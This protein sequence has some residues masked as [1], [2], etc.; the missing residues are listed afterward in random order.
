MY[1]RKCGTNSQNH[2]K[3]QKIRTVNYK[4]V[5]LQTSTKYQ[6]ILVTIYRHSPTYTISDIHNSYIYIYIYIKSMRKRKWK[7]FL[8]CAELFLAGIKVQWDKDGR[9]IM[10]SDITDREVVTLQPMTFHCAGDGLKLY[11]HTQSTICILSS[12]PTCVWTQRSV[13]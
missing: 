1:M 10:L 2:T 5:S 4:P 13:V 11:V 6:Y 3:Q 9:R 7:H 12:V 8:N